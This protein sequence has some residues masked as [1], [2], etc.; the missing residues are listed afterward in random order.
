MDWRLW[1]AALRY[2]GVLGG[3][4]VADSQGPPPFLPRQRVRCDARAHH[5]EGEGP[6][7]AVWQAQPPARMGCGRERLLFPAGPHRG[8]TVLRRS[9]VAILEP[10]KRGRPVLAVVR[11]LGCH[12]AGDHSAWQT[13]GAGP[14]DPR[15]PNHGPSQP[16]LR[17]RQ[18]REPE[19]AVP[20]VPPELRSPPPPPNPQ[21]A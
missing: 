11:S 3:G 10:G 5:D 20:V 4:P 2:G 16:Y 15:G 7:R 1:S 19:N 14:P 8:P 18:R 17:R 9:L 6:L 21:H 13:M 12:H